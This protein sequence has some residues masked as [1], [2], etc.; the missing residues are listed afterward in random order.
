MDTDFNHQPRYIP[1]LLKMLEECDCAS[2]SRFIKGGAMDSRARGFLSGC[3]NV[4]VRIITGGRLTDY[5]YGYLAVKRDKLDILDMDSIFYGFGDYCIRLL[6]LM[7]KKEL[8]VR[9]IP[10]VNGRRRSGSSTHFLPGTL[11]LYVKE[12]LKMAKWRKFNNR[13]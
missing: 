5:L 13:V 1:Y 11:L 10:A 4:F 12:T 7:E 3:F 9:E 2:A 6:L 8:T